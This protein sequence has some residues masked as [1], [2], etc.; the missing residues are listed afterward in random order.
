MQP[1][2]ELCPQHLKESLARY[3]EIKIE[4]GGFLTAILEN[5]LKE[6]IGRADHINIE[7]IPHIV[8][9][10]YNSLPSTCW[11]SPE[12]VN[13]WLSKRNGEG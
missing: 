3:V 13:S 11:G 7:L 4:C 8:A 6:A 1:N 5:N 10:C 12:K 2:E 9:Y